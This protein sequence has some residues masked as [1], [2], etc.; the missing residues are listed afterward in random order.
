MLQLL[1]E[2]GNGTIWI[3]DGVNSLAIDGSDYM[4]DRAWANA[5][6]SEVRD[7]LLYLR[8]PKGE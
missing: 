6:L 1:I 7:R 8:M 2:Q 3:R 4:N 5:V